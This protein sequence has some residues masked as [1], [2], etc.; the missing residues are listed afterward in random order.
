MTLLPEVVITQGP[1]SGAT[2]A[3]ANFFSSPT[4]SGWDVAFAVLAVIAAWILSRVAARGTR[5][6]VA[7]W[8]GITPDLAQLMVRVTK[9]AILLVGLGVALGF[10]GAPVQPLLAAAL[11]VGVVAALALRGIADNFGAGVVLQTRRP[12]NVGDYLEA[13]GYVGQVKELNGRSVI[14]DVL[15]G[16]EVHLPNRQLLDTPFVNRSA[17]GALLGRINLRVAW[18]QEDVSGLA[19]LTTATAA[20]VTKVLA[21]PEPWLLL[22]T[23]EP[24]R[25]TAQL[26]YWRRPADAAGV[27]SDVVTAVATQLQTVGASAV[28]SGDALPPLAPTP[29]PP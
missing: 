14:V 25:L 10:L 11:I 20:R 6:M 24:G 22:Q 13:L 1:V 12:I 15:D 29:P 17:S 21:E 26:R 16:S 4:I 19:A 7:R 9:Y 8:G 5:A 3:V 27:D 23:S 28:V 18:P 2:D